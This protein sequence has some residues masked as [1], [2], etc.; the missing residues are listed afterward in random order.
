MRTIRFHKYLLMACIV[1]FINS[2]DFFPH[3][4]LITTA[5]SPFLYIWLLMKRYRYVLEIFFAAVFPFA[6]ASMFSGM[7]KV[8]FLVSF[9]VLMTAY[10]TVYAFA[11]A[12]RETEC[13][14]E[15]FRTLIWLNLAFAFLGLLVRFTPLVHYMWQLPGDYD[16]TTGMTR[17]RGLTY[18]PSHYSSLIMPLVLY[19]YWLH[20]KKRTYRT[21]RLFLATLFPLLMAF[22]FSGIGGLFVSLFT[23]QFLRHRTEARF[24]WIVAVAILMAGG[25][26]ALPSTSH[27]KM[28]INNIATGNDSSANIRTTMA[29][30]SAYAMAR[31][32]DI[33]F[34][35]GIGQQKVVDPY[36][37]TQAQQ[38]IP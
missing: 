21:L 20:V 6:F 4:L 19:S 25:Y 2:L 38:T 27:I 24:K 8:D 36:F 12:I 28:R 37:L 16:N 5:L 23:V 17:F 11:V 9:V 33:W 13:L 14:D 15:V 32:R 10:V 34:G 30:A 7:Q 22:A 1:F 35:I 31:S 18:E 29:Y 26:F 3:G